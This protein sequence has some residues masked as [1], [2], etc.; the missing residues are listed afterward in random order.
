MLN[1]PMILLEKL[2]VYSKNMYRNLST[3]DKNQLV[4]Q[5][6]RFVDKGVTTLKNS[7]EIINSLMK[8]KNLSSETTKN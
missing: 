5:I 7:R 2:E 4:N 8:S 6:E 3:D 1:D